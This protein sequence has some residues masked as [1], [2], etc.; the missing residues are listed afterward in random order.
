MLILNVDKEVSK[1]I[2]LSKY[3]RWIDNK[4]RRESWE[5]T[6]DRLGRFWTERLQGNTEDPDW[7]S[8]VIE[9][10]AETIE[11]VRSKEVMPSMR[12]LWTAGKALERDNAAGF[13]CAA[14]AINHPRCFDEIFYLLMCGSGV[15]FSVERQYINQMPVVSEEFHDTDTTIDVAD[16]K[17]GWAK[18]LK[19][20]IALLYNGDVPLWD[21]SSIRPAGARLRTFGG[22]ASGPEPLDNLF[23]HTVRLFV[24]AAG[25]KLNSIECHDL[26]C[27]I[28]QTVIVGSVRRSA[29]ISLSNLTDDRMARAKRGEWYLTD[30]Q[31]ALAN[32]SVAYTEKP[33]MESY[34]KE[35]RNLYESKAG[36]R[37]IVNKVALKKR[38]EE[39]GRDHEGDYLL[40]P[41]T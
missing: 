22:R 27:K 20:L 15:G 41:L 33:D 36:E 10:I 17:I 4:G 14:I 8:K 29:T 32:N 30:P 24:K 5:E 9:P 1:Y 13:N 38:A 16:S 12:S 7:S 26:V 6:V 18:G 23:R 2:H 40:N 35:W 21:L 37:G 39:C 28:A 25:R 19:E 31:R 11:A 34:L 3:S